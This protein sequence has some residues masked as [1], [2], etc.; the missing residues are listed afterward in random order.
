LRKY[1]IM[2]VAVVAALGFT[3]AVATAQTDEATLNSSITP[4]KAGTAK[5]PK[6]STVSIDVVNKNSKRT[7]SV[8]QI[9]LPKTIKTSGKGFNYCTE[10]KLNAEGKATCPKSSKVGT[11]TASALNG[12]NTP[13]PNRLTFKVTAFV[14][15]ADTINFYLEAVELPGLKVTAPGKIKGR[16]LTITV[17]K[18]AQSPAPGTYAGL[19]SLQAKLHG[20]K[21][22]NFLFRS[23]G[24]KNKV[25]KVSAILTFIDNGV[26]PA[27]SV[28]ASDTSPC[29][30]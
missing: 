11:G 15:A 21:G 20:K 24:C 19:E 3:G 1:L 7:M 27:G 9:V 25:N 10:E 26:S 16:K 6:D 30:P 18:V 17:P 2:V 8:L 29:K 14:G 23:V 13:A 22:K 12:V 5:K 4:K 28:T